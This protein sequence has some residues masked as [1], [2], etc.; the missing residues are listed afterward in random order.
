MYEEDTLIGLHHEDIILE[1]EDSADEEVET[2]AMVNERHRR[3][4]AA[5]LESTSPLALFKDKALFD[6]MLHLQEEHRQ[7]W[8]TR[9]DLRTKSTRREDVEA[10]KEK[11]KTLARK[12][13]SIKH[14]A[15]RWVGKVMSVRR[16]TYLVI[17]PGGQRLELP[18]ADWER[19][20]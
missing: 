10:W 19:M 7:E 9:V 12:G 13:D 17:R 8:A 14:R 18:H 11:R 15:N 20:D 3:E 1:D 2:D 6:K 16:E 5:L 4:N